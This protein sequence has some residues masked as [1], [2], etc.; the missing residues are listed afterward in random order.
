MGEKKEYFCKGCGR[1]IRLYNVDNFKSL[2]ANCWNLDKKGLLNPETIKIVIEENKTDNIRT[3]QYS[4]K[5]IWII[6]IIVGISIPSIYYLIASVIDYYLIL[7]IYIPLFIGGF[8]VLGGICIG[9][10]FG[11]RI[12]KEKLS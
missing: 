6:F 2:C 5:I 12:K 8:F 9:V 3:S 7:L 1:E 10:V 11:F 4:W